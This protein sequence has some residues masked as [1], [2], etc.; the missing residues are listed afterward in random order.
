[1]GVERRGRTVQGENC[2]G[3]QDSPGRDRAD[4]PKQGEKPFGISKREVWEAYQRVAANKGAPGVDGIAL[5][6]FEKDLKNN[7]YRIWNRMSS[8]SYFP[9]PVRAVPIPK[10]GGVRILGVPTIADRIAQTVVARRLEP[11]LEAIFHADSDGYRVG[12]SAIDA[13]AKCRERCWRSD[14]V[15]DLDVQ[16][17]FDSCPHDLIVK[18]VEANTDQRWIVLY[19]QR[20]LVAPLQHPD[21]SLEAREQG[22]P[23]GS[24]V[25]PCLANLF[26]H[27]AFDLWMARTF[28]GVKFERYVDDAVVHCA[29]ER[30]AQVVRD[31]IGQRMEQV[32]LRL[33]PDK[34]RTVYCQDSN[35]RAVYDTIS[36]DFLGYTFRPRGAVNRR[37]GKMFTS[38]GPAMSRDKM[39]VKGAEVRRWRLHL[40]TGSTLNDLA[41]YLNSIVRGWMTYWGHFNKS[42][43]FDLLRRINAYLMRWARKKYR[44]L[45][46]QRRLQAWWQ[47]LVAREPRLFAHWAWVTDCGLSFAGR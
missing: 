41:D 30:E 38:F 14:W 26:L 28:P 22:T 40:R 11:R 36:F 18:A 31:A 15:I 23:Q 17:F 5:E 32:G 37:T 27:Y 1:M 33:H 44:R 47:A 16:K 25:S 24:A 34:T 21:G 20:W 6:A 46:N 8:G 29:T 13:V 43:M 45:R 39:T 19:V 7:L 10:K 12:R 35:R 9:P 4:Q 2:S 42:Q 3:N